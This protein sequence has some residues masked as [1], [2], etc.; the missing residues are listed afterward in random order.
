M[1]SLVQGGEI[2]HVKRAILQAWFGAAMVARLGGQ[3]QGV[4]AQEEAGSGSRLEDLMLTTQSAIRLL[5]GQRFHRR[6]FRN[7]HHVQA[8]MVPDRTGS[9]PAPGGNV[10][11]SASACNAAGWFG[12][13]P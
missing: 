13:Y 9:L 6:L 12:G 8:D 7:L 5:D 2:G 4:K 3:K 1:R 11:L 10:H